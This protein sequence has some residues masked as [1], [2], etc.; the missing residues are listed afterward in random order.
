MDR[1]KLSLA[2]AQAM[3]GNEISAG[4]IHKEQSAREEAKTALTATVK[5]ERC[6]YVP[7]GDSGPSGE[8]SMRKRW[9]IIGRAKASICNITMPF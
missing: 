1:R 6:Y 9:K 7:A 3:G 5:S 2:R 4:E 8:W